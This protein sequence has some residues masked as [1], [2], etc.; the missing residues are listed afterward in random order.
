MTIRIGRLLWAYVRVG[1]DYGHRRGIAFGWMV[2]PVDGPNGW[3]AWWRVDGSVD[4]TGVHF[5]AER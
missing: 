5:G 3:S 1:L 2:R 4:R